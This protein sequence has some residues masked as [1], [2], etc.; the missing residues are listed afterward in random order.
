V[1]AKVADIVV[2]FGSRQCTI[3]VSFVNLIS[4][5]ATGSGLI[6]GAR[7]GGNQSKGPQDRMLSRLEM[8]RW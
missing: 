5:I 2:L 4:G 6:T 3:D 8:S 1:E 7:Y